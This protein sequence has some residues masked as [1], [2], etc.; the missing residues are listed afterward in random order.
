MNKAFSCFCSPW[1][2]PCVFQFVKGRGKCVFVEATPVDWD[3]TPGR[4]LHG[5]VREAS[6]HNPDALSVLEGDGLCSSS[7]PSIL[8]GITL[9]K[10]EPFY[11]WFSRSK[12][13]NFK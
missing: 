4:E 2:Y 10:T 5:A 1:F 9:L 12:E 3:V 11:T 7:T 8:V 6:L 13:F